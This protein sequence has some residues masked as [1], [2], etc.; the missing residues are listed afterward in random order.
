MKARAILNFR[1][2]HC[3]LHAV[4]LGWCFLGLCNEIKV[5]SAN[6][7]TDVHES[8]KATCDAILQYSIRNLSQ[9]QEVPTLASK[10]PENIVA[11]ILD[12]V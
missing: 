9:V 3:P 7:A 10:L 12:T 4:S 8:M 6:G 1:S 2:I 11:L 5:I